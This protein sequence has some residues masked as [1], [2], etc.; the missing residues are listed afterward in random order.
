MDKLTHQI[1]KAAA[2]VVEMSE[3]RNGV[4][5]DFSE[6]SLEMI[7]EMLEESS[8]YVEQMSP[9][10]QQIIVQDFGSYILEVARR[11]F[12]GQYLWFDKRKQPVLIVGVPKYKIALITW[13]KVRGRLNGD[14]GDNIPF[15]YSGFSE[16]IA[17]AEPGQDVLYT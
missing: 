6:A 12:G 4:G 5:L 2:S 8:Q 14:T 11:K 17:K 1:T 10:Q 7:E 3:S 9:E 16:R 15:F 13:D